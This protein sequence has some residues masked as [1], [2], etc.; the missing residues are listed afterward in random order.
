MR[1]ERPEALAPA[2]AQTV[3]AGR[4]AVVEVLTSLRETSQTVTSPLAAQPRRQ[5]ATVEA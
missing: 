3:A 4:P 2:F 1:V 5:P